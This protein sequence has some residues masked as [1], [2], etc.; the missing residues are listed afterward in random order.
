VDRMGERLP[1]GRVRRDRIRV[2]ERQVCRPRRG[3]D[4]GVR[5]RRSDDEVGEARRVSHGDHV[6]LAVFVEGER[7]RDRA[8]PIL[9]AGD[10]AG[11]ADVVVLRAPFKGK[12][13]VGALYDPEGAAHDLTARLRPGI[14]VAFDRVTW[15]RTAVRP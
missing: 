2:V 7:V 1:K 8:P 13:V 15:L 5:S 4:D 6:E 9:D 11:P 3:T 12:P 14:A 10:V